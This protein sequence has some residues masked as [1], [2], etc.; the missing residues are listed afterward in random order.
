MWTE[1]CHFLTPTP[2]TWKF[3]YH[4]SAQNKHFL[5]PDSNLYEEQENYEEKYIRW[6]K[7]KEVR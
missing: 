4:E 1:I 2:L 6:L 7:Y 5:T 3:L